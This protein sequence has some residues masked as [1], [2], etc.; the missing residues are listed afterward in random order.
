MATRDYANKKKRKTQRTSARNNNNSRGNKALV[1]NFNPVLLMVVLVGGLFIAAVVYLQ[2]FRNI[3]TAQYI[4][5]AMGRQSSSQ[6][7]SKS[8]A[9]TKLVQEQPKFEFYR[10]LPKME[11]VVNNKGDEKTNDSMASKT[12]TIEKL[13]TIPQDKVVMKPSAI[14]NSKAYVLQLASFKDIDD[15]NELRAK[16]TLAG[17]DIQIETVK[18]DN[19][20][21]WHRVKTNRINELEQAK[22]LSAQLEEHHIKSML[23]SE[24][25]N[26]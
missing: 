24:K 1:I 12:N 26:S 16:L 5:Q 7:D 14:D 3:D 22:H 25:R 23:V 15:A 20:D 10:T 6:V 21:I 4:N 17:F 18:L 13:A 11:V 8:R 9:K 19:G 2:Y